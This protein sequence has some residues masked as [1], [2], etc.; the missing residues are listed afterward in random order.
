[1]LGD[2]AG[3]NMAEAAVTMPVV[4]LVLMFVLNASL[5][6]Y[7]GMAAANAANYAA[8]IGATAHDQPEAWAAAAVER[9]MAAS[10]AGK[11]YGYTIKVDKEPGGAVK[12]LVTW[13]YPSMLSGL[14]RLFGGNC[15]AYF[16]GT[17][18]ATR[19][20]EGW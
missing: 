11:D 15:P 19:K 10:G 1:M 5:A 12:V 3:S 20:R 2:K 4:L 14:C 18:T 7:R 16:Y 17:T 6:G 9:A 13:R 8:E